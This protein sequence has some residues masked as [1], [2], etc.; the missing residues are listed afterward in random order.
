MAEV[1]AVEPLL[2]ATALVEQ[3]FLLLSL[4]PLLSM[5]AAVEAVLV[6]EIRPQQL[7]AVAVAVLVVE[8]TLAV[9]PH[10]AE[11]RPLQEPKTL[12]VAVELPAVG[13]VTPDNLV[14]LEL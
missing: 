10:L 12:E 8:P 14:A 7:E 11:M 1:V 3:V 13:I 9:K 2:A 6:V 5:L 4:E